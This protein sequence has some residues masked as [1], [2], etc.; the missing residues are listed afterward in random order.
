MRTLPEGEM[1]PADRPD[2]IHWTKPAA[3]ALAPWLGE[4]LID[5]ANGQPPLPVDSRG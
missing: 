5:I 2:G 4:S 3:L 1:S